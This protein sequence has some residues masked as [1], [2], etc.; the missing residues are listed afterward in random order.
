MKRLKKSEKL[1]KIKEIQKL[2]I[3]NL[4]NYISNNYYYILVDIL[5]N[6]SYFIL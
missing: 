5:L 2:I 1:K 6:F 3:L 4:N